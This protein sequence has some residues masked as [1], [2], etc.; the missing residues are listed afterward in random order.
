MVHGVGGTLLQHKK[1]LMLH[2]DISENDELLFFTTCGWMMWNW[3]LSA[4]SLGATIHLYD[5]NP[6]FPDLRAMWQTV[7]EHNVT[8][9][10]TSG[11]FL[12][13]CMKSAHF[14]NSYDSSE[15][16]RLR[17]ILYTGSPLSSDGFRW[18]YNTI[19]KNVHLAGISGGTD[20][21]SCFILGNPN[22]PVYPGE[23]QCK[24][25]GVDVTAFDEDGRIV[26][27]APGELVCRQPMPSMPIQFWNDADGEKYR[28][29]YFNVFPG[30]WRHGDFVEF[31]ESGG[32]I[33]YGRSDTTLNPGGVRIGT[34]EIYSALD[35]IPEI[36]G[37]VAVG[38]VPPAESDEIILLLVSLAQTQLDEQIANSIKRAI[39]TNCSPRHVP[40]HI[41]QIT[42]IP[43]TR[44][45]KTVELTVKALLAGKEAGNANALANPEVLKE[46][47]QIRE[48]LL[49][50]YV[51]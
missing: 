51:A 50:L 24:G 34:A 45:G 35:G 20:I 10:G 38:W 29:A 43:V 2:C 27:N 3:Q 44:S 1:E 9:F 18:V 33:V 15:L 23:I 6:G 46:I 49:T 40:T 22:L 37:A 28:N 47:E 5:G 32:A 12:E 16:E 26:E 7:N 21:V 19:K 17:S 13:S 39:R 4:L 31:T 8:H 30:V 48:K 25:L 41:F 11:R 42:D 14:Q 36:S